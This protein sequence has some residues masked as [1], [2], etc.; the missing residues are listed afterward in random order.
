MSL[1]DMI[2]EEE[3]PVFLEGN[4][5][6]K[7]GGDYTFNGTVISVFWKNSGKCRYAVEDDRGVIHIYSAANLKQTNEH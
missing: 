6:S 7:V 3:P 4:K 5:V 1:F 2:P